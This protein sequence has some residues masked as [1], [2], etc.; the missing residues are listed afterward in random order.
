VAKVRHLPGSAAKGAAKVALRLGYEAAAPAESFFVEA[1][2]GPLL[3]GELGRA[4]AWGERLG[5]Q[6]AVR[7]VERG[8]S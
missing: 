7:A 2:R 3:E 5:A 8:V 1:V 6:A 4:Q